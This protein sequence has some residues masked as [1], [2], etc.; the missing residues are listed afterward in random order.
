MEIV[1]NEA[2]YKAVYRKHKLSCSV[3]K[4]Q[5]LS[6]GDT[7]YLY[8]EKIIS[9]KDCGNNELYT[10][11]RYNSLIASLTEIEYV[12]DKGCDCIERS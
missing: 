10:L 6:H 5:N 12:E 2:K 8:L 9:C 3:C 7:S 1:R 4:S 11:D